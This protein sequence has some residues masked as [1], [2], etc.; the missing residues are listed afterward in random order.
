MKDRKTLGHNDL[1]TEVTKLMANR[2]NPQ[3]QMI[4]RRIEQL[5]EV[6]GRINSLL[7]ILPKHPILQKEYLERMPDRKTYRYLVS[8]I[9]T[10]IS[11]LIHRL[12]VMPTGLVYL[13]SC[14]VPVLYHWTQPLDDF[15]IYTPFPFCQHE[16]K[17]SN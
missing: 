12:N 9:S 16:P 15:Y 6:R 13:V 1:I 5:I 8:F 7:C 10:H 11:Q 3:P 17:T 2:F 4:K 14:Y